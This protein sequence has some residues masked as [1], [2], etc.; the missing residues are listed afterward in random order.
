MWLLIFVQWTWGIV[1][2]A[3]G[4]FLF[5]LHLKE[6][7]FYYKGA[8]ITFW[9]VKDR[10]MGLGMF[11][12]LNRDYLTDNWSE[13]QSDHQKN[14]KNSG[15]FSGRGNQWP[16]GD[17]LQRIKVHEYGHTIQSVLLGPLFLP[18]IGLPS[19]L[20]ANLPACA[21]YRRNRGISY[22]SFYTE[23][24]ANRLGEW[25]TGEESVK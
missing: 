1:Q 23:A 7:H 4:F 19:L 6:C 25:V 11:I 3:A 10:S 2:N 22:Y 13:K 9:K 21:R 5:L 14:Q 18:V 16:K 12:F 24:W 8:V 17:E 15:T 20:W